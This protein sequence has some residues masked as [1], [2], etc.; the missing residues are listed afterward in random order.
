MADEIATDDAAVVAAQTALD[1]AEAARSAAVAANE[2]GPVTPAA[3][4]E[5]APVAE[6]PVASP[7]ALSEQADRPAGSTVIGEETQARYLN[8]RGPVE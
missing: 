5:A 8:D 4:T 6:A 2:G 7:V 1:A 3:A